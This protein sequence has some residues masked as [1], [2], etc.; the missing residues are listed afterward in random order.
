M[1]WGRGLLLP[2]EAS[3]EETRTQVLRGGPQGGC[4]GGEL[5]GAREG[6]RCGGSGGELMAG[7]RCA[8]PAQAPPPGS[9]LLRVW[10]G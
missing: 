5:T 10:A 8:G 9:R 4:S 3:P 1:C 7:H 6:P 2:T